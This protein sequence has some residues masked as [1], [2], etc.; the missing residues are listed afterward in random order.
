M[1]IDEVNS[2]KHCGYL[3]ILYHSELYSLPMGCIYV[4][5]VILRLNTCYSP[6]QL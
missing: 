5:R 6:K 3:H 1:A 2:L 4:F